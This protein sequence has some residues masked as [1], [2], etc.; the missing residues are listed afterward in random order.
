MEFLFTDTQLSICPHALIPE[1]VGEET[2][3]DPGPPYPFL[4]LPSAMP[5]PTTNGLEEG[6]L[7]RCWPETRLPPPGL[8]FICFLRR[9]VLVKDEGSGCCNGLRVLTLLST[10]SACV[11]EARCHAFREYI[12]GPVS[13]PSLIT[14]P[15]TISLSRP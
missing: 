7:S 12:L 11:L 13:Y 5:L 1:P 4:F 6:L 8:I 15:S 10:Q 9:M 3:R 2:G 14:P